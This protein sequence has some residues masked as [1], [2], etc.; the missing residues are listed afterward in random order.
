MGLRDEL[1]RSAV[2][3]TDVHVGTCLNECADDIHGTRILANETSHLMQRRLS[4]PAR[5]TFVTLHTTDELDRT[6]SLS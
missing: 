1:Q 2:R 3:A 5:R 4:K 6:H